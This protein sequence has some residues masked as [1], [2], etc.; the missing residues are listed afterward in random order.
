MVDYKI[1]II[2]IDNVMDLRIMKTGKP[3]ASAGASL[4]RIDDPYSQAYMR[5]HVI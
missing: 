4:A 5:K 1:Y 3:V 2:L